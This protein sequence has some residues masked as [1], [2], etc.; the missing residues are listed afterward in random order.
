MYTA[1]NWKDVERYLDDLLAGN[2][3][4]LTKRLDI[5]EKIYE[6]HKDATEKIIDRLVRDFEASL[7]IGD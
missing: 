7:S 2:D 3:P 5:A 6:T 1:R 4:L